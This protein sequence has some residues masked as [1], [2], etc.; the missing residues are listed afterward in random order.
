VRYSNFQ[1]LSVNIKK[2][3][4]LTSVKLYLMFAERSL[5]TSNLKMESKALNFF[6]KSLAKG[7]FVVIEA[8]VI[9]IIDWLNSYTGKECL[10]LS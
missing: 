8:R 7:S 1:I 4:E 5:D 9:T 6:F 10:Y 2:F 3:M